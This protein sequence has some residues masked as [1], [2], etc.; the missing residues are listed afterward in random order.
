[1]KALLISLALLSQPVF[2]AVIID[3]ATITTNGVIPPADYAL[4]LTK[5]IPPGQG[6][7]DALFEDLGNGNF[8]FINYS[9]AEEFR[10][11]VMPNFTRFDAAYVSSHTPLF[12]NAPP[13]GNGLFS[14]P[15]DSTQT[16][17]YWDK[18]FATSP[19]DSF[20][21]VKVTNLPTGPVATSGATALGG[22]IIVG[23]NV[24]VPEPSVTGMLCF[25]ALGFVRCRAAV[26]I[27]K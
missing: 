16:F 22:G 6:L 27:R 23:T 2:A 10:I 17:A 15:L 26:R 25:A 8:Q 3:D 18:R 9:V 5:S 14:I 12:T 4:R 24:Q 7:L 19:G 20:G 21:W 1:M 11:Y 13:T